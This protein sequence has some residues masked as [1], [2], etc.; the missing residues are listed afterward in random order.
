MALWL[1]NFCSAIR[2][3]MAGAVIISS[4]LRS[5][6]GDGPNAP[7]ARAADWAAFEIDFPARPLDQGGRNENTQTEATSAAALGARRDIGLP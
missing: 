3:V 6:R 4:S 5:Q 2:S 7:D 1:E